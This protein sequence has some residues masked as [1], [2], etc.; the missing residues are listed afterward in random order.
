M[1]ID[2]KKLKIA[3]ARKEYSTKRLSELMKCSHETIINYVSGR[4]SPRTEQ[5]GKL[6]RIL[7]VD[8]ETLID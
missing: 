5:L 4:T 7:E 1:N 3:M 8:P 6:A 2:T